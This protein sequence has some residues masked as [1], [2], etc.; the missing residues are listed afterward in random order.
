MH[1]AQQC[2]H[3]LAWRAH[4]SQK[5]AYCAESPAPLKN[6][7]A[8]PTQQ[9]CAS[10]AEVQFLQ[11]TRSGAALSQPTCSRLSVVST[12]KMTGTPVGEHKVQIYA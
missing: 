7:S 5:Q 2:I 6:A 11:K 9:V 10:Q 12:P 3:A 8:S 1:V 4:T